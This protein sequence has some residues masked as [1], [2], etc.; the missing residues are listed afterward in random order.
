MQ[1]GLYKSTT[2]YG[3]TVAITKLLNVKYTCIKTFF[4]IK[5]NVIPMGILRGT[6]SVNGFLQHV[7][8]ILDL[9]LDSSSYVLCDMVIQKRDGFFHSLGYA[10]II[11]HF[12]GTYNKI[13]W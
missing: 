4:H 9:Q 1:N 11:F 10:C 12:K 13:L 7:T 8:D 2:I 5:I 6:Y 3:V